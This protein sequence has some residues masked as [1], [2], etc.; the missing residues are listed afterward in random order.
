MNN[1]IIKNLEICSAIFLGVL[2]IG[3]I[4]GTGVSESIILIINILFLVILISQKN[5]LLLKEKQIYF[6]IIIWLYLLINLI[7]ANNPELSFGRSIFFLD[8]Y[9]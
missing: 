1:H 9:C 4:V 5:Y 7:A 8:T 3:L 2:P 6:L